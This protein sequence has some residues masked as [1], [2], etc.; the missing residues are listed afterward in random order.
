MILL[1][2]SIDVDQ[3]D[4][5]SKAGKEEAGQSHAGR[6]CRVA[7]RAHEKL[8]H[9]DAAANRGQSAEWGGRE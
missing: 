7:S 6:E 3:L 1:R 5:A 4:G 8:G 2:K 9:W